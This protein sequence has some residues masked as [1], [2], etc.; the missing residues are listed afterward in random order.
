MPDRPELDLMYQAVAA[1]RLQWDNL[2]WQV[3]VLSLTAQAF[4][5]TTALGADVHGW[6]RALAALLS[7]IISVL[8][9]LLMGR[10]RQGELTGAHW[11]ERYEQQVLGVGPWGA[12]GEPVRDAR[13]FEGLDAG[14]VGRRIPLRPM[15]AVWVVGLGLFGLA[16]IGVVVQTVVVALC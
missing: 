16:A 7:L 5:F 11:L 2:L 12:H 9:I 4:L 14:W 8:S 1:R 15:F 13:E 3:P 6:A 10:H